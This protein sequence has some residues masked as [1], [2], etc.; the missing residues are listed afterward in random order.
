MRRHL[1][2]QANK[3]L[4]LLYKRLYN[5]HLPFHLAIKLFDHTI[6][7]ILT[8]SCEVWGYEDL[9]LIERV[10]CTFLRKLFKLRKSTPLYMLYGETGRYPLS[11]VIKSKIIGYWLSLPKGDTNRL[12]FKLYQCMLNT[13]TF[14]SKWVKNIKSILIETGNTD[15]WEQQ[16]TIHSISIKTLIDQNQQHW[17]SQL[18]HSN[19]EVLCSVQR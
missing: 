16:D 3:A 11:I 4:H 14:E 6:V 13:P 17:H 7:P 2:N 9:A 8:C 1:V 10:H 12:S 18:E 15:L 5:L 19:K